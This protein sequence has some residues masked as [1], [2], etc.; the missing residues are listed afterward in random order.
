MEDRTKT[1]AAV[2]ILIGIIV[3]IIVVI[4]VVL[5]G[6]K[7]ISPVPPQGSIKI[8]FISPTTIPPATPSATVKP[9][10]SR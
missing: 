10:S 3:V 5:S 6:T 2:T 9:T 4:G 8:I 1:I 7:V